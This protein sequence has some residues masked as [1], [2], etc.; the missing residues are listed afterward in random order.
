MGSVYNSDGSQRMIA[1]IVNDLAK[2]GVRRGPLDLPHLQ[3]DDRDLDIEL[4]VDS[5]LWLE[6]EGIIRTT[7]KHRFGLDGTAYG[8]VL[9]AYGYRLLEQNF[10]GEMKLGQAVKEIAENNKSFSGIGDFVGGLL[11]GFTKSIST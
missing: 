10:Q 4:F 5:I 6:G 3:L 1:A 8:F 9:T 2:R 7:D 11:G